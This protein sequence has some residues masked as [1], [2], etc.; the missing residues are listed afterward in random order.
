MA[1]ACLRE[2]RWVVHHLASD[3]PV[4][5]IIT[6]ADQ[7]GADLVV[8]SSATSQAAGQARQAA[9]VIAASRPRLTVLAGRPGDGLR[10]LLNRVANR[11]RSGED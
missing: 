1:A 2:S 9:A 6:L 5:E 4:E 7:T 8:L 3:L 11:S 10:E